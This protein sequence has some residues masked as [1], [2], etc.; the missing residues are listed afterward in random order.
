MKR[1]PLAYLDII[2]RFYRHRNLKNEL[3]V[4]DARI[5]LSRIYRFARARVRGILREL[6]EWNLIKFINFKMIVILWKPTD[7][8]WL[9]H[10]EIKSL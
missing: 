2:E 5:I 10:G 6:M 8:Q 1:I 7:K 3:P 4:A 9:L